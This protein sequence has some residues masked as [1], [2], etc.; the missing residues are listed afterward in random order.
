MCE[1]GCPWEAI[2]QEEEAAVIFRAEVALNVKIVDFKDE[3]RV[4][5]IEG[6]PSPSP[7]EVEASHRKWGD[8]G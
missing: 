4:P 8:S 3:I 6:K 2:V 5:A 7:E 1:P